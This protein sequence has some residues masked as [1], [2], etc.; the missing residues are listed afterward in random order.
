MNPKTMYA[1]L[2][3]SKNNYEEEVVY[4]EQNKEMGTVINRT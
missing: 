2:D 1:L 4:K 3:E